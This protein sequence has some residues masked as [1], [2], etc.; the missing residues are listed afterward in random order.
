MRE[1]ALIALL[2]MIP[3]YSYAEL[4]GENKITLAINECLMQK[5]EV[6]EQRLAAYLSRI[7]KKYS[8]EPKTLSLLDN[9]QSMWRSFRKEFCR[10]VYQEFAEGTVGNS[11]YARCN[12]QQTDRRTHDLWE[13][14]LT[15]WDSTPP[16]LQE[17]L[18]DG[19]GRSPSLKDASRGAHP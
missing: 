1:I 19:D 3:V 5:V 9:S 2:A 18:M 13:W 11:I 4:C 14:Y 8:D 16:D 6:S 17:P 10:S 7:Q 15:Y 12:L